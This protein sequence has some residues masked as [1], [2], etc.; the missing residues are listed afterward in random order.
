[1]ETDEMALDVNDRLA[2]RR[3]DTRITLH[4]GTSSSTYSIDPA[5]LNA[6]LARDRGAR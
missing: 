3:V 4:Q 2:F 5:D 6:A 1:M